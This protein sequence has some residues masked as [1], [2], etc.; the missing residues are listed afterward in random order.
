MVS[1]D[2]VGLVDVLLTVGGAAA[3]FVVGDAL[4]VPVERLG[5][6][7]A[8][9]RPWWRCPACQTPATRLGLLPVARVVARRRPCAG[10]GQPW[11]HPLRPLV[12]AVVTAVVLGVLSARFG[13]DVALAAYAVFGVALVAVSAVDI[14]RYII[15]NRMIY[16]ALA[17]VGPLLVLS[18]G[19]D[20]RWAS[21]AR[22]A[23]AGAV[24]FGAMLAVHV[25]YPKGMGFGDVRLAGLVAFAAGWLGLGH[26]FVAFFVA[27]VSAAVVG[28]AVMVA[29]GQGRRTRLYFGPFLALGGFVAV[30]WGGPLTDLLLRRGGG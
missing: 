22:A 29:T 12:L 19:V 21:L 27:F 20:H 7:L 25:A 4:E 18:S 11:P 15:P 1:G 2:Q 24:G 14:E 17:V 6:H 30:V 26:A 3:G 28:I 13:A 16:P 9:D 5:A 23:I 10:C 8:L